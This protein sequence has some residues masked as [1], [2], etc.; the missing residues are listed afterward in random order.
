M[1]SGVSVLPFWSFICISHALHLTV[2]IHYP[3]EK[4]TV[5]LC[6]FSFT[7]EA[8]SASAPTFNLGKASA[9]SEGKD[10]YVAYLTVP[11]THLYTE[12]V[13]A[14]MAK[15]GGIGQ[16][17]NE[18]CQEICPRLSPQGDVV[19]AG[20]YMKTEPLR[21]SNV[22]DVWPDFGCRKWIELK[23]SF[24]SSAIGR[25]IYTRTRLPAAQQENSLARP[26]QQLPPVLFR[27]NS[28]W[29]WNHPGE[30]YDFW[31]SLMVNGE[32]ERIAVVEVYIKG[33]TSVGWQE[34]NSQP[35][36]ST[37]KLKSNCGRCAPE[38]QFICDQWQSSGY[39][40][41]EGGNH[42]FGHAAAFF[43]E[44]Y[45]SS[46]PQVLRSLPERTDNKPLRVGAWGYC[47]GGL[48]AWNAITTQPHLFNMA[49]IG[50]PA[51]DFDCGESFHAVDK[52]SPDSYGLRPKIYID[53]GADEGDMM[54][55]QS[56][57]L[58]RKL[59]ERGLVQGKD[60][61]YSRAPFGTHQ[62]RMFLRRA[63]KALLVMFGSG[64]P[65]QETYYEGWQVSSDGILQDG[66]YR[67]P[68]ALMVAVFSIAF[69]AGQR[70]EFSSGGWAFGLQ[71]GKN[72]KINIAPCLWIRQL[73]SGKQVISGDANDKLL[74]A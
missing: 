18:K 70:L 73:V 5:D 22:L 34:W 51:M 19:M 56:L 26:S 40:R 36:Y 44:L 31:H 66:G 38:L 32:M 17:W 21:N 20:P 13:L 59:Q 8:A 55:R 46:M 69:V 57:L 63:Q 4:S 72:S 2:N 50:S 10:L 7:V 33:V 39:S 23:H 3:Q 9:Q 25:E 53:S 54:N 37:Q 48:A 71:A 43:E 1:L 12:A 11:D 65:A 35:I 49:Y 62:S 16:I 14:V 52:I 67:T 60:V 24:S 29:Y 61:F 27:F 41:Y 6:G 58:F 42:S 64:T 28:E 30:E 74:G 45:Q 15:H 47:I 68:W